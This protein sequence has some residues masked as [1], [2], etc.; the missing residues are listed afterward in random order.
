MPFLLSGRF[1]PL[2]IRMFPARRNIYSYERVRIAEVEG[3][4]AG[5][6][7]GYTYEQMQH[8]M[9]R[10]ALLLLRYAGFYLLRRIP[11]LIFHGL[12][13]P[14]EDRGSWMIR[15]E[16]F[17]SNMAVKPEFRNHGLGRMLL[18]DAANRARE[19]GCKRIVLDVETDN[20][21]A[22]RLYEREGFHRDAGAVRGLGQSEFQRFSK[23]LRP[24]DSIDDYRLVKHIDDYRLKIT[25]CRMK[26]S[27]I[28]L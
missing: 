27:I 18:A 6:L 9:M 11:W 24:R 1:E 2:L 17:A 15:G 20:L 21:G 25:D 23:S 19:M 12:R 7:L 14:R 13:T 26:S 3:Q 10:S 22:I 5:M 4:V 28:N 8:E 16:F